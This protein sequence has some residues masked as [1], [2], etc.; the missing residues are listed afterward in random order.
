MENINEN[1]MLE[2]IKE[3]KIGKSFGNLP[4]GSVV[5]FNN[6]IISKGYA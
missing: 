2:A 5:V 4:F 3:A 6:E 1:F